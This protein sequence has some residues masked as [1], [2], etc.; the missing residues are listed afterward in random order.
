MRDLRASQLFM[1]SLQCVSMFIRSLQCV[2]IDDAC[3]NAWTHSIVQFQVL[4]SCS[5]QWVSGSVAGTLL[6]INDKY[7]LFQNSNSVTIPSAWSGAWQLY[8]HACLLLY[9][10]KSSNSSSLRALQYQRVRVDL[11]GRVAN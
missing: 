6:M 9:S 3:M 7:F 5:H 10:L 1:R 8:M 2:S 11:T 4:P